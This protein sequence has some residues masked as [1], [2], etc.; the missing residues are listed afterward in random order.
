MHVPLAAAREAGI[1][2]PAAATQQPGRAVGDMVRVVAAVV[3]VGVGGV[4]VGNPLPQVAAHVVQPQFVGREAAHRQ[5]ALAVPVGVFGRIGAARGRLA[6]EHFLLPGGAT[7]V[8]P[9]CLGR[10]TESPA[11]IGLAEAED[12]GGDIHLVHAVHRQALVAEVNRWIVA[13]RLLPFALR[14]FV[15]ADPEALQADLVRGLLVGLPLAEGIAHHVT[16]SRHAYEFDAGQRLTPGFLG[17]GRKWGE[18]GKGKGECGAHQLMLIHNP[19]PGHEMDQSGRGSST[20]IFQRSG[21]A[22]VEACREGPSPCRSSR[23]FLFL[24]PCGLSLAPLRWHA[25][26]WIS[27]VPM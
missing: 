5:G 10:Q 3:Q 17:K 8:F 22:C 6:A 12:E 18:Q 23:C 16:A 20:A 9:L 15:T 24:R 25:A 11:G 14:H 2:R 26:F 1:V 7:G 27:Q 19:V 21:A 4:D 13:D